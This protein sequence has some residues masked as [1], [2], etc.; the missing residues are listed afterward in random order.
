[1]SDFEAY[2]AHMT[3]PVATQYM[4]SVPDRRSAWRLFAA[5]A[6]VWQLTGAGW[7]VMESRDTE[8]PVGIVGAFFR[9]T[10]FPHSLPGDIEIGWSVFREHWRKGYAT[11]GS[12]AVLEQAFARTDVTRVVAHIDRANE[13]SMGVSR[14]IGLADRGDVDFYDLKLSLHVSSRDDYAR[15]MAPT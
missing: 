1:M 9:E 13:A 8:Q 14:A 7:W 3:D 5:L 6:G 2:A 15:A 12:R 4:S 11:E 10:P